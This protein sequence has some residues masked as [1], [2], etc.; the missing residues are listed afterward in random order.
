M[1]T[2]KLF[3]RE[4]ICAIQRTEG[5]H[6]GWLRNKKALKSL[7]WSG[8]T[9]PFAIPGVQRLQSFCS[10]QLLQQQILLMRPPA[11]P[12]TRINSMVHQNLYKP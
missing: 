4:L 7:V 6:H 5:S 10:C 1:E 8:G 3:W 9:H 12:E 11:P 2:W